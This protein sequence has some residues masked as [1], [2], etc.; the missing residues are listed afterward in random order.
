MKDY[1]SLLTNC[2]LAEKG[3][4]IFLFGEVVEDVRFPVG[5][6][7][8][9]SPVVSW[10]PADML[11]KTK[12]GTIYKV[13]KLYSIEEYKDYVYKTYPSESYRKYLLFCIGVLI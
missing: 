6:H 13:D 2:V 8:L 7:I 10:N 4:D 3:T 1:N 9:T 11:G 12:S 5:H